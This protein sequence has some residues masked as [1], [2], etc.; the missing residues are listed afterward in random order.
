MVHIPSPLQLA[1]A[2][3]MM[4][5][6]SATT[7]IVG[8][9]TSTLQ[10]TQELCSLISRFRRSSIELQRLSR[11]LEDLTEVIAQIQRWKRTCSSSS[12]F[13]NS[14]EAFSVMQVGLQTLL[15]TL[16]RLRRLLKNV[17]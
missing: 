5:P 11:E 2:E 7:G 4:D 15:R 10:L 17:L 3:L 9:A 6:F 14:S 13:T 1:C 8:L 12:P 16:A